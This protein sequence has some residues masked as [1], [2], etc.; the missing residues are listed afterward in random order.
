MKTLL[1]A[2]AGFLKPEVVTK[3]SQAAH[4]AGLV[5][6]GREAIAEKTAEVLRKK[7]EKK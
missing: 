2:L 4:L 1:E 5:A 7:E 6:K 3:L